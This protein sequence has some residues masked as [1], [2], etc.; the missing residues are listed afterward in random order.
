MFYGQQITVIAITVEAWTKNGTLDAAGAIAELDKLREK[1]YSHK[2][3]LGE[4][5]FTWI[6]YQ[7]FYLQSP[8]QA[9]R[10]LHHREDM[11]SLF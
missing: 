5:N 9:F 3:Y 4:E 2:D 8:R 7:A 10:Q 6:R 1:L 11:L